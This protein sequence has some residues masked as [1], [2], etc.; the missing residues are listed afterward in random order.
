M[1][2]VHG[3]PS[4]TSFALSVFRI[5]HPCIHLREKRRSAYSD[6]SSVSTSVS[7]NSTTPTRQA[8]GS[9]FGVDETPE[10]TGCRSSRFFFGVPGPTPHS[11]PCSGPHPAFAGAR[12]LYPE[13]VTR[14]H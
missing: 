11:T 2:Q 4:G 9:A 5:C 12:P 13:H 7:T 1:R 10:F 14:Y 3:S 6:T 8:S